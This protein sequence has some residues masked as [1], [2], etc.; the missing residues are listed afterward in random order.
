MKKIKMSNGD[1]F[2]IK[3]D[4]AKNLADYSLPNKMFLVEVF[5]TEH[6][7]SVRTKYINYSQI[8]SI[9]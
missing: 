4:K 9:E 5:S 2:Y 1:E 8:V 6:S 3:D 7:E